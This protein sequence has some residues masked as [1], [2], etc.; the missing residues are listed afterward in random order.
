MDIFETGQMNPTNPNPP[1]LKQKKKKSN[2]IPSNSIR[3][4]SINVIQ[5]NQICNQVLNKVERR[6]A[7]KLFLKNH[8]GINIWKP[9]IDPWFIAMLPVLPPLL[10]KWDAPASNFHWMFSV[11]FF[12]SFLKNYSTIYKL[13]FSFFRNLWIWAGNLIASWSQL[14]SAANFERGLVASPT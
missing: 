8:V 12:L 3:P 10:T 14:S 7:I 1:A 6:M 13:S 4:N 2:P 9:A 11:S 5:S